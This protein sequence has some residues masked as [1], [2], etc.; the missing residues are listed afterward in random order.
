MTEEGEL[1]AMG[2][3]VHMSSYSSHVNGTCFWPSFLM[4]TAEKNALAR[5]QWPIMYVS[6]VV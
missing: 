5:Y 3:T 6:E 2:N 4:G 1:T